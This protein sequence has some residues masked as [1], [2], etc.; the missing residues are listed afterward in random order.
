MPLSVAPNLDEL[1]SW[2]DVAKLASV[3]LSTAKRMSA[4]GKLLEA[5]A[6]LKNRAGSRRS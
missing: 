5:L 6:E 4:E 1:I 3:S 2:M